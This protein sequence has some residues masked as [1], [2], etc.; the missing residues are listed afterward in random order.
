[1]G[2][3]KVNKQVKQIEEMYTNNLKELGL[4][5]GAVGW[6]TKECQD[7][8]FEMLIKI[9]PES[10]SISINDYGCGYASIL[11]YL[12]KNTDISITEYNGYDISQEMLSNA[13]DTAQKVGIEKV[14]LFNTENIQ[15]KADFSFVSGTFNVRFDAKKSDWIDF[16]ES[17]LRDINDNSKYGFAFNLLTSY[18]DWEE[19]H[20]FYGDPLYWFDFCKKN[21]SKKVSLI[22]DYDLWEWTILVRK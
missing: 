21:F 13:R 19:K 6:N 20:L 4:V 15:T 17:K 8:R 12:D 7:L 11:E 18:V 1:M 22:H 3:N 9:L 2:K 10:S 5:S 16:I 14:N